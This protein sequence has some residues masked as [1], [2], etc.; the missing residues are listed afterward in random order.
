VFY[1]GNQAAASPF[2]YNK[3]EH[4]D[5][6]PGLSHFYT[7]MTISGDAV[8]GEYTV[9]IQ[10]T[11]SNNPNDDPWNSNVITVQQSG[12]SGSS[13]MQYCAQYLPESLCVVLTNLPNAALKAAGSKIH[14][15]VCNDST[16]RDRVL[17]PNPELIQVVCDN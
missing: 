17:G 12:S 3:T 1:I 6:P 2:S 5:M 4:A 16:W 15:T 9:R 13:A 7:P 10:V 8:P 14:D 11:D